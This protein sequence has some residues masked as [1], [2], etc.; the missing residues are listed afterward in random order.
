MGRWSEGL[1]KD[2]AFISAA[3]KIIIEVSEAQHGGS[4]AV[5]I[6]LAADDRG[7]L[8]L[9]A[10]LTD[11]PKAL[12]LAMAGR[13]TKGLAADLAK[14]LLEVSAVRLEEKTDV[15]LQ[16]IPNSWDVL[17]TAASDTLQNN[18]MSVAAKSAAARILGHLYATVQPAD[19]AVT[20]NAEEGHVQELI[21]SGF[22]EGMIVA[23]AR[24]MVLMMLAGEKITA[25][26]S[27]SWEEVVT[28]HPEL[29]GILDRLMEEWSEDAFFG[30]FVDQIEYDQ[31]IAP[32]VKPMMSA[33]IRRGA[34]GVLPSEAIIGDP[35]SYLKHLRDEDRP[36]FLQLL[37]AQEDFFPSLTATGTTAP[38]LALSAELIESQARVVRTAARKE[39]VDKLK[40]VTSDEWLVAVRDDGLL[41]ETAGQLNAVLGR[42]IA[43]GQPLF[44]ALGTLMPQLIASDP[45]PYAVRWFEAANFLAASYRRTLFRNLRDQLLALSSPPP[46]VDQLLQAGGPILLNDGA[47]ATKSD[48]CAR[49]IVLPLVTSGNLTWLLQVQDVVAEWFRSAT[50][51]TQAVIR[52]ALREGDVELDPSEQARAELL[53]NRLKH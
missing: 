24:S 21:N 52:D 47:F 44:T 2:Q 12:A 10:A 43:V 4:I 14:Q 23:V 48:E 25:P 27:M 42:S 26:A 30:L 51:D 45:R 39:L 46:Q 28:A 34:V 7:L 36:K 16:T 11:T 15:V 3:A 50:A 8:D 1:F 19:D 35:Q 41:M 33:A 38:A 20:S 5:P 17:C 18:Q 53:L 13:P 29:P 40:T 31:G 37:A 22:A 49:L 9:L 32:I 6:P